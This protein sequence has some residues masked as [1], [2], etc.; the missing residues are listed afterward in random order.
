MDGRERGKKLRELI[1]KD[2]EEKQQSRRPNTVRPGDI[3][4]PCT[5]ALW[6]AFHWADKLETF[7]GRQ[8]RLF[9]TGHSQE[10]RLLADVRRTGA[11]V[12]ARNPENGAEQIAMLSLGGHM[13]GYLDGVAKDV[14][15]ASF[16]WVLTECKTHNSKSFKALESDGVEIAKPE[17]YAQ[18]QCYLAAHDLEEA[19]YCAV[20]KDNDDLYMEYIGRNRTYYDRLMAKADMVAFSPQ[21]PAKIN[22]NPDFYLCK[23]CKARDTCQKGELPPRNCR[24]CR[25]SMPV[26]NPVQPI[27][28]E[29]PVWW[30]NLHNRE[31]S[32]DE[33]R[34]GCVDHRYISGLVSGKE[35]QEVQDTRGFGLEY[36]MDGTGE[37][38]TDYGPGEAPAAPV[39]PAT[40]AE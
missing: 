28:E 9:E 10:D 18:M 16:E 27:G 11:H 38:W 40:A 3:G 2:Y 24:T 30:C 1:F 29:K 20:G 15:F 37:I 36:Q 19:L 5:L 6:M 14:P 7:Q 8:L 34:A 33:Q 17:H 21:P 23:M 25:E 12:I 22:A 26:K 13:K 32:L 35:V 4:R 31:L 39:F